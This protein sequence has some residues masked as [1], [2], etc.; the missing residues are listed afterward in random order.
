M[1]HIRRDWYLR[2]PPVERR[3]RAAPLGGTAPARPVR[4]RP[5]SR[6]WRVVPAASTP[7]WQTMGAMV[8]GAVLGLAL[9]GTVVYGALAGGESNGVAGEQ[10]RRP[11]V[12]GVGA[13][14][15]ATTATPPAG[16]SATPPATGDAA[17]DRVLR[18][19]EQEGRLTP[20]QAAAI[21]RAIAGEPPFED[22]RRLSDADVQRLADATGL[23][24]E[25]L[26]P[27]LAQLVAT[28]RI[29]VPASPGQAVAGVSA[30]RPAAAATGPAGASSGS[31]GASNA[32]SATS[33]VT[34]AGATGSSDQAYGLPASGSSADGTSAGTAWK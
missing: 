13:A 24:P 15:T 17:I 1:A 4:P 22:V 2:D 9:L 32:T 30:L 25:Q 8:A 11:G 16:E 3:G 14:P 23:P 27:V 34:A 5:G 21:S 29:A 28:G 19:A 10:V 31:A 26:A 20:E 33:K 6:G 18:D 7:T 12:I